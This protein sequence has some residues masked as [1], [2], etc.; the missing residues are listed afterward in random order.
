MF[1]DIIR[2]ADNFK[3]LDVN[4]ILFDIL[5]N[6]D[7][8][9]FIRVLNLRDQLFEGINSLDIELRGYS[10]GTEATLN[11]LGQNT[12]SFEGKTKKKVAGE[13]IFLFDTGDFYESFM[14][15]VNTDSLLLDADGIK[16]DGTD[17]FA[18]FGDD[19]LGLTDEN[20]Q[21][22]IDKI[23]EAIVPKILSEV[24]AEK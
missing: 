17:L 10:P 7:I 5:S 6:P 12:F 14:I 3:R 9:D 4:R 19:I 16:E 22:L 11:Q 23:S 8:Q 18:E 24:Q 1:D 21:L 20:L 13:P 15:T 2:L